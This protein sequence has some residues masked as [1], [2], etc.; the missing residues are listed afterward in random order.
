M[1]KSNSL[2]PASD[3]GCKASFLIARRPCRIV[4]NEGTVLDL[5]QPGVGA[6][7]INRPL[8]SASFTSTHVFLVANS[9]QSVDGTVDWL[10]V[11]GITKMGGFKHVDAGVSKKVL[12]LSMLAAAAAGYVANSDEEK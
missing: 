8:W 9:I 3:I 4:L 6:V 10:I 5:T 1:F 2:K 11:D 12:G 7:P